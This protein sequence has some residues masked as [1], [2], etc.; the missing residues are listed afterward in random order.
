MANDELHMGIRTHRKYQFI[1]PPIS[2]FLEAGTQPSSFS[3]AIPPLQR[4]KAID[5]RGTYASLPSSNLVSKKKIKI[6][7]SLRSASGKIT[8]A[9]NKTLPIVVAFALLPA[10]D[11]L[12]SPE[13]I[14]NP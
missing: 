12:R 14:G 8:K 5:C 4:I 10:P 1:L 9:V 7:G 3:P 6:K 11:S 13:G 2:A